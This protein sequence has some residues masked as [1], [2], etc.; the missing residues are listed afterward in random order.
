MTF[1]EQANR[2]FRQVIDDYHL[3]DNVDAAIHNPY[4]RDSIEYSLYTKIPWKAFEA[5]HGI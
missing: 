1:T 3:T 4:S 2:I 5:I